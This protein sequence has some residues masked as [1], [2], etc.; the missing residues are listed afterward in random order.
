MKIHI[1]LKSLP[2]HWVI[3]QP[4]ATPSIYFHIQYFK[5]QYS[6]FQDFNIQYQFSILNQN[7]CLCTRWPFRRE[8]LRQS[9]TTL[10]FN[11]L[12]FRF[13]ILSLKTVLEN[14]NIFFDMWKRPSFTNFET[15]TAVIPKRSAGYDF[16]DEIRRGYIKD[17][18]IISF[19]EIFKRRRIFWVR[20]NMLKLQGGNSI[21]CYG[22]PNFP[23][24]S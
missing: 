20:A 21:S 9:S 3:I 8:E 6:I 7:P 17:L 11:I 1:E 10:I 18:L 4:W 24:R 13:S 5:I 15:T 12:A 23:S 14:K 22:A 2:L 19:L 16:L